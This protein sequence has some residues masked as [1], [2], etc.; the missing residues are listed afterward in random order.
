MRIQAYFLSDSVKIV[1]DKSTDVYPLGYVTYKIA[2][3]DWGNLD[4]VFGD[5]DKNEL[6][7]FALAMRRRL[8][9]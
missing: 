2:T 1:T 7:K 5:V 8:I 3:D 6:K 4:N 9:S